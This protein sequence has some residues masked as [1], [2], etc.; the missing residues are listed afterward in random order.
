MGL[1][2]LSRGAAKCDFFESDRKVVRILESN[3][4]ALGAGKVTRVRTGDAWKDAARES[5]KGVYDLIFLDPPYRESEDASPDGAVARFLSRVSEK[6]TAA[7][8]RV[9]LVVLH[10]FEKVRFVHLDIPAPWVLWDERKMGSS[11][12]TYF[13]DR[14]DLENRASEGSTDLADE[15]A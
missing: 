4:S 9:P 11:A 12:V 10:H 15:P 6:G 8:F 14:R 13:L 1:E 2:A 5:A 3:I 7:E